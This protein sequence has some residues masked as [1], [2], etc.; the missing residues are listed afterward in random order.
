MIDDDEASI[1]AGDLC[2]DYD[3][4]A[5]RVH[6]GAALGDE[7]KALVHLVPFSAAAFSA[8][9][10][11]AKAE[12]GAEL[13]WDWSDRERGGSRALFGDFYRSAGVGEFG[14]GNQQQY[15]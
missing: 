7:I 3:S 9:R 8:N 12:L 6:V 11:G 4:R 5:R 2:F 15:S 1:S 13:S 10:I 14:G